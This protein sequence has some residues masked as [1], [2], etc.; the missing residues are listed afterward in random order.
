MSRSPHIEQSDLGGTN[1]CH[2]VTTGCNICFR[3]PSHIGN[4]VDSRGANV[5]EGRNRESSRIS[6]SE[7]T[8]QTVS[9]A[10]DFDNRGRVAKIVVPGLVGTFGRWGLENPTAGWGD[11]NHNT[12]DLLATSQTAN[13]AGGRKSLATGVRI[14]GDK[15]DDLVFDSRKTGERGRISAI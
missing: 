5:P 2:N 7:K 1:P 3:E 6:I 4:V 12:I 13:S 14:D 8:D 15:I 10:F 11:C 9:A